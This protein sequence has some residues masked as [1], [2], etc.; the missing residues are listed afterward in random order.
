MKVAP[1]RNSLDPPPIKAL[2]LIHLPVYNRGYQRM[3]ILH[4][5]DV[6]ESGSCNA[7]MVLGPQGYLFGTLL[8]RKNFW[9]MLYTVHYSCLDSCKFMAHKGRLFQFCCQQCSL[10]STLARSVLGVLCPHRGTLVAL[11]SFC[12]R[13]DQLVP[14]PQHGP[15][16]H[17]CLIA[18]FHARKC[19]F[20]S[21]Y[22]AKDWTI[23][24]TSGEVWYL[25]RPNCSPIL[26]NAFQVAEILRKT[27]FPSRDLKSLLAQLI[28]CG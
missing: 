9:L 22:T 5:P 2:R 10:V 27:Q 4:Q 23:V 26:L 14:T 16:H 15:P 24:Q 6:E 20:I 21:H 8:L 17:C 12:L 7:S 28:S 18:K 19:L 11:V 25:R 1:D 3:V 13:V